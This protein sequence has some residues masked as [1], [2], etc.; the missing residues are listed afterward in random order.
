MSVN[1]SVAN[2]FTNAMKKLRQSR[3]FLDKPIPQDIVRELLEVARWTGSSKNTQPWEFVVVEDKATIKAMSEAGAFTQFLDGS[4]LVIMMVL[5]GAAPRSEAYDEGRLSERLMIAADAFGIGSGTG[6][7]ST[8]DAQQRVREILG[9]PEDRDV[10]QAVAF[11][12][13]DPAQNQRATS[14]AAGRKPLEEL[15]SYGRYGQR[16]P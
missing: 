13:P 5:N 8:A 9:I 7:F 12:Y 2:E 14:A 1:Q 11:G 4:A 10:W 16:T 3:R 15:V 6:W